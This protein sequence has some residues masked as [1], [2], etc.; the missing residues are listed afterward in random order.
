LSPAIPD[1]PT[2][3]MQLPTVI[4]SDGYEIGFPS[5]SFS[6][7]S[8]RFLSRFH[9][10]PWLMSLRFPEFFGGSASLEWD[11]PRG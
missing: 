2:A 6:T 11:A 10:K 5:N 1:H 3:L 4:A 7:P 9:Y 8:Q